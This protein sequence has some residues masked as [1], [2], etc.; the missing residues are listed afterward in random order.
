MMRTITAD[1]LAY[2]VR[3]ALEYGTFTQAD[4]QRLRHLLTR[5]D[6]QR[7][8]ADPGA[9]IVRQWTQDR[10]Y[11][12][13][14]FAQIDEAGQRAMAEVTV[15]FHRKF[16]PQ[17]DLTVEQQLAAWRARQC[18][19]DGGERGQHHCGSSTTK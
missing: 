7:G 15:A 10:D 13:K 5:W 11:F 12:L 3:F 1:D 2:G 6:Y 9:A 19:V 17:S 8:N 18:A 4:A 14:T 16:N